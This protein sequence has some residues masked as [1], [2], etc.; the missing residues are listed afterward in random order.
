MIGIIP[1]FGIS[2]GM[3][4]ERLS[5]IENQSKDIA[6]KVEKSIDPIIS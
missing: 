3:N 2:A 4:I 5:A 6:K 1:S